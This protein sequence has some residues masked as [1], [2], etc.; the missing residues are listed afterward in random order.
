MDNDSLLQN[1][2]RIGIVRSVDPS[3]RKARVWY[4][5]LGIVSGWLSVLQ[6]AGAEVNAPADGGHTHEYGVS[7]EPSHSHSAAVTIAPN[8]VHKHEGI[9]VHENH[10][11]AIDTDGEHEHDNTIKIDP[12]GSHNHEVVG[13]TMLNHNHHGTQ[14]T[15]WMPKVGARVLVLYLPVFNGDGFILGGL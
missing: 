9:V 12:D 15:G 10:T 1:L 7:V 14:V 4:D 6:L 11:L 2:V 3:K 8:G 13:S 5:N